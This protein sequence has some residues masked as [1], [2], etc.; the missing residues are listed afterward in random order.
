[1]SKE[2]ILRLKIGPAVIEIQADSPPQD[3]WRPNHIPFA[4]SGEKHPSLTIRVRTDT[5]PLRGNAP[6]IGE[7]ATQWQLY[8]QGNSRRLE[9]LEQIHFEP[10][11]VALINRAFDEADVHLRPLAS[12]IPGVP[13]TGWFLAEVMSPLIQWWL[14]ARLAHR[15]EGMILH[16][17]AAV[18]RDVGLA[19]VGPSGAGKTTIARWCRDE[20]EATVLSDDR[21]LV[22]H[23][24]GRWQVGGTPWPGEL[25]VVSPVSL[26]LTALFILKKAA[27]NRV[28]RL[29]PI[30]CLRQLIPEAFLPIWTRE[31]MEGL[32]DTATRLAQEVRTGE[33]EFVNR[34]SVVGFLEEL[35]GVSPEAASVQMA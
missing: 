33:L 3:E 31:G 28:A 29:S 30:Q 32:M 1:M 12:R 8:G 17:S 20:A 2:V 15:A 34:P 9:V 18:L 22:W 7:C 35:M 4:Y 13:Q 11:Q 23:G 14:T 26:P 21:I 19:F 6:L 27:T 10:K 25:G 16:G 24:D 5:P